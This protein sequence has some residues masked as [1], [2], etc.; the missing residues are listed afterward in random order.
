MF[1][2]LESAIFVKFFVE[3]SDTIFIFATFLAGYFKYNSNYLIIGADQRGMS[4]IDFNNTTK[5]WVLVIGSEARG[6]SK[7]NCNQIEYSLSIPSKGS[8]N[9]LNAAVAGSIMLYC[10]NNL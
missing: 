5:A 7:E 9:S 10:L 2:D 8:G 3:E 6:I 4:I 1:H